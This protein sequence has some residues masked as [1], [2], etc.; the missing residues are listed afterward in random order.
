MTTRVDQGRKPEQ[1]ARIWVHTHPGNSPQPSSVDQETFTRVFGKA[2]WAVMIIV[3]Q[4]SRTYAQLR[5]GVGPGGAM[6]IPVAVDYAQPF[7][8]TDHAGWANEY[9]SCV[10]PSPILPF[11]DPWACLFERD[12]PRC[13]RDSSLTSPLELEEFRDLP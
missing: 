2:D 7:S 9:Q 5:F 6:T 8:G 12:S 10:R 13:P 11:A 4:S 3:A 1:F